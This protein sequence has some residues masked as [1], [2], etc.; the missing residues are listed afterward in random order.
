MGESK[1]EIRMPRGWAT[2]VS[3]VCHC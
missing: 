2:E 3:A 1:D